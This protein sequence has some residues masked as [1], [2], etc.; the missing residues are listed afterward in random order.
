MIPN[1]FIGI[2]VRSIGRELIGF[3]TLVTVQE[4]LHQSRGV[5]DVDPVPDNAQWSLQLP[6]KKPKE[7]HDILG[8]C[9]PVVRQ[10]LEVEA[11]PISPGADRD[12]A[13][14][15][16]PVVARPAL[17]DRGLPPRRIGPADQ[18]REHEA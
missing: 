16:D 1:P 18:G 14:C 6:D 11:Q 5:V 17:L 3:D 7:V 15:R 10:Q 12:R 8:S 2:Q 9:V 13:D 4:L